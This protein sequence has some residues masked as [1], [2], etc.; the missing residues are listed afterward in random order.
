MPIDLNKTALKIAGADPSHTRRVAGRIEF[1][2][3]QGPLR[4]DIRSPNFVWSD[5]SLKNLAKVLWSAQRAHSYALSAYR[6][7]S[8]MQ[9]SQFSP[10]GL[11]GGKGYIQSIKDM[12][13]NISQSVEAL[14][15]FT[16]TIL[17]E[18]NAAHWSKSAFDDEETT[19]LI[20]D[21]NSVKSNPEEFVD[22]DMDDVS[23]N[24]VSED[25][26]DSNE[27]IEYNPDSFGMN[28]GDEIDNDGSDDSND[29]GEEEFI[30]TS[31]GKQTDSLPSDDSD[32]VEGRSLSEDFL[33]TVTTDERVSNRL[34]KFTVRRKS[35]SSI[36]PS[37]LSGP[38]VEHIE[39]GASEYGDW[40]IDPDDS[41]QLV[42]G[43]NVSDPIYEDWA[44]DGVSGYE[45]ATKGGSSRYRAS[46]KNDDSHS[47]VP[48]SDNRDMPDIYNLNMKSDDVDM[49]MKRSGYSDNEWEIE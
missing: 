6:T 44:A 27:E 45:D 9:S 24:D 2:R 3:D 49:L 33:K 12:R 1:V 42:S 15:S 38:R 7:F 13:S 32:Q 23:E 34:R 41:Q 35:S 10:D 26:Y 31:A 14:S 40:S 47:N 46:A 16:D 30:R 37:T 25:G 8:K 43:V 4:R 39:P 22:Q 18:I 17:D 21:A 29:Y 11:L 20:D 5:E 36:D 48:G 28:P 19:N